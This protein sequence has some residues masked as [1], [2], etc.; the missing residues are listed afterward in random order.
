VEERKKKG[1]SW[2]KGKVLLVGVKESIYIL[3]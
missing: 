2:D 1:G 3:C